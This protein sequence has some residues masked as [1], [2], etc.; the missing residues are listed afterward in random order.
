MSIEEIRV[1]INTPKSIDKLI[2]ILNELK[3]RRDQSKIIHLILSDILC[4]IYGFNNDNIW[5]LNNS[6]ITTEN[7]FNLIGGS[8]VIFYNIADIKNI[9]LSLLLPINLDINNSFPLPDYT[10]TSLLAFADNNSKT[11]LLPYFNNRI[12]DKVLQLYL[13]EF[14][15]LFFLRY[16]TI[17]KRI[18][19][20]ESHYVR[21]F[22]LLSQYLEYL[23]PKRYKL[24]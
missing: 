10:V 4:S 1:L 5:Y 24:L 7:I 14:F 2:F 20:K 21:Y 15:I 9:Q 8:S 22:G 11:C 19:I 12:K 13:P 17:N 16:V 23:F 18:D 3:N 6:Y